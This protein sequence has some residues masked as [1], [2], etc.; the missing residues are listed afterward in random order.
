M[1]KKQIFVVEQNVCSKPFHKFPFCLPITGGGQQQQHQTSG[2]QQEGKK[3]HDLCKTL[4]PFWSFKY[5][6]A[7]KLNI[8]KIEKNY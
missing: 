3:H 7:L 1:L 4:Y 2:Q 6:K 8:P 5:Q